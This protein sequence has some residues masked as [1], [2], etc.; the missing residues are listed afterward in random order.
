MIACITPRI[1]VEDAGS[2]IAFIDHFIPQMDRSDP[3]TRDTVE[4]VLKVRKK[5]ASTLKLAGFDIP[6]LEE[7]ANEPGS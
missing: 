7:P 3:D 4:N 6:D 5:V 2:L 1:D